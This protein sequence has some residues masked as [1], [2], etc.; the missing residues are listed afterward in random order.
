VELIGAIDLIDGRSVR[1]QQGDYARVI[2]GTPDPAGLAREWVRSGMQRLHLVD[3]DGARAGEPRQPEQLAEVARAARETSADVLIQAGGG[4]RTADA[5]A[6]LLSTGA[7]D[8]AILG[9]AALE[10]EGF[11]RDCAA[12]WPG[13]ILVSLDLRDGRPALDGWLREAAGDPVAIA[14]QLLEAGAAGLLIT[15]TRRDGTLAGPNLELLAS[16]REALPGAW[17][18][19]A[20]GIGSVD[21]LLAMQRIGLDGAVAGLALLDGSIQPAAALAALSSTV[22]AR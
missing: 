16:F 8:F 3:L 4:L 18:A 15:D 6:S 1:L 19:G 7:V 11:V 9:T 21:D 12:R 2:E 22:T 5:A 20:G 14:R 13:R 10:R 17:L